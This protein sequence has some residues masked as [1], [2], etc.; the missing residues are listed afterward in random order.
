[1]GTQYSRTFRRQEPASKVVPG[2]REKTALTDSAAFP[3][4]PPEFLKSGDGGWACP[5]SY[6][7]CEWTCP[8]RESGIFLPQEQWLLLWFVFHNIIT[9]MTNKLYF[10]V[11]SWDKVRQ[12]S[13]VP[14]CAC[15]RQSTGVPVTLISTLPQ[16]PP[17]YSHKGGILAEDT[18]ENES[19][20]KCW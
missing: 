18:T 6:S 16:P 2:F 19:G 4:G 12:L 17:L 14:R 13:V 7:L 5:L 11:A 9:L 20:Q 3:E 8:Y 10:Q 15:W 1:M